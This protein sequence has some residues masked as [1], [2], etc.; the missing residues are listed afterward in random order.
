MSGFPSL[1]LPL[2]RRCP[3]WAKTALRCR[4]ALPGA[5]ALVT[6]SGAPQVPS[7]ARWRDGEYKLPLMCLLPCAPE[8]SGRLLPRATNNREKSECPPQ[9]KSLQEK[10]NTGRSRVN[11]AGVAPNAVP[12]KAPAPTFAATVTQHHQ[13][14]QGPRSRAHLLV[15]V[16]SCLCVCVGGEKAAP[17]SLFG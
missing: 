14:Q 11:R 16:S 17:T 3:A 8:S 13:H 2:F 7:G 5:E 10:K 4:P 9:P 15:G 12:F 6:L 1:P